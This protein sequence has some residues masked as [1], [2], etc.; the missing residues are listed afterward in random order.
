[1]FEQPNI[2]G[3]PKELSW[4]EHSIELWHALERGDDN[5]EL[6][7]DKVEAE[8]YIGQLGYLIEHNEGK[9]GD[10]EKEFFQR[11]VEYIEKLKQVTKS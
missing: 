11:V 6:P 3:K 10:K 7:T 8:S 9:Y 5:I 1:M 4:S 2:F